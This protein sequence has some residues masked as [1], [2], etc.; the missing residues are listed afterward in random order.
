MKNLWAPWR[1]TFVKSIGKK[2]PGCFFCTYPKQKKDSKNYILDRGEHSFV[3]LNRYPYNSGHLMVAPYRHTAK[4][5]SLTPDE[6]TEMHQ[7]AAALK[8]RL[9]KIAKPDG[10]NLGINLGRAAGAGV[11]GHIH[12]HLVPRWKGDTNFMP[13]VGETKVLP[14]S[15]EELHKA[16]QPPQK[17]KKSGNKRR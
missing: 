10:Y 9:D 11:P 13:V 6:I 8:K 14:I 7:L 15:L 12:L 4:L 3:I 16:L 2:K 5:E 17:L 1:S